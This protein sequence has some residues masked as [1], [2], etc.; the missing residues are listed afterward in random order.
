MGTDSYWYLPRY[1]L[2]D[3]KLIMSINLLRTD[4][5]PQELNFL[6]RE[7]TSDACWMDLWDWLANHERNNRTDTTH[8]NWLIFFKMARNVYCH[9]G[10]TQGPDIQE[11]YVKFCNLFAGRTRLR[12]MFRAVYTEIK[13]VE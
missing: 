13:L 3:D 8:H 4:S 12:Q 5:Y 9:E 2:T 7:C 1:I 10:T 6:D 11:M